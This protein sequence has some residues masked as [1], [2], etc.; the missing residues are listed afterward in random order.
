M[1]NAPAMEGPNHAAAHD[2]PPHPP[3]RRRS[4]DGAGAF[5]QTADGRVQVRIAT[6]HG[7]I[8]AALEAA[9]AP[10]TCANFLRYVDSPAL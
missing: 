10:I 6:D 3:G 7:D 1:L 8:L 2:R 9:K 4:A 5:A